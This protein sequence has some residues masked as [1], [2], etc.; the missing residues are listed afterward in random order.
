MIV[1]AAALLIGSF[2]P[3]SDL[4]HPIFLATGLSVLAYLA[5]RARQ[6]K[7]PGSAEPS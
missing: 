5:V 2:S 1:G 7:H 6:S 4:I 3:M